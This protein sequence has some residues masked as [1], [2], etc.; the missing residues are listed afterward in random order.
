MKPMKKTKEEKLREKEE[1]EKLAI[2]EQLLDTERGLR[3]GNY[4]KFS[5]GEIEIITSIDSS[6]HTVNGKPT[7]DVKY[8]HLTEDMLVQ[9]GFE[10]IERH[11]FF[12]IWAIGKFKIKHYINGYAYGYGDAKNYFSAVDGL[13]NIYRDATNKELTLKSSNIY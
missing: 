6:T 1:A 4:T 13:Q 7:A 5:G 10:R 11:I 9:F 8:F 2:E 3:I 12:D